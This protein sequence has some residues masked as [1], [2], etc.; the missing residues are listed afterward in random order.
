MIKM[1]QGNGNG[2]RLVITPNARR[3][4]FLS[5]DFRYAMIESEKELGVLKEWKGY[6]L[7]EGEYR[8][9]QRR[10]QGSERMGLC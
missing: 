2:T 6:C 8:R 10:R 9:D 4:W 5:W 7:L 3:Q 1:Q